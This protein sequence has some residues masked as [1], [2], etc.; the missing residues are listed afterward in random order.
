MRNEIVTSKIFQRERV[1]LCLYLTT[2]TRKRFDWKNVDEIEKKFVKIHEKNQ[3]LLKNIANFL[4]RFIDQ[5]SV[6]MFDLSLN[7]EKNEE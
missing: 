3:F 6:K 5:K 7:F 2:W 4:R 1:I